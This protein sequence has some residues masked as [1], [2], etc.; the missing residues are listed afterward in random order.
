MR[1]ERG[2]IANI[3][4]IGVVLGIIFLS[5]NPNFRVFSNSPKIT[6]NA[7]NVDTWLSRGGEAFKAALINE[8]DLVA[9]NIWGNIKNYFAEKFS[10]YSGTK[11]E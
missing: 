3:L 4:A 6:Q 11:V 9:K 1:Q 5:Q 7:S 10:K 2:F 8:K